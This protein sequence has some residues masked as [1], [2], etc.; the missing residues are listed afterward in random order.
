MPSNPGERGAEPQPGTDDSAPGDGPELE[1]VLDRYLAERA[2]GEEPDQQRYLREHPA[3]AEALRGVFRTLDFVE[4]TSRSLHASKLGCG[5]RV[6]E[7]RIVREVGRGGM[8][9]VYEAVQVPLHRRVALKVLPPGASLSESA[10]ERFAREAATAGRLHHTNI[11]PVYAVGQQDELLYYA[12]QFIDGRSLAE[13]LTGW[14]RAD[15]RP[16]LDHHRRVAGWGRQVAE[17]IDY[18]HSQGAIHRDIK[19]ANLLLDERDDVWITDFGLAREDARATITISGDVIG[20]ARYM[21]PE[22]AKGGREQLDGRTDVYSLGATLYE[23]LA[24]TPAIDDESREAV[25]N[26]LATA[27]A[28]PLR[29]IDRS[30][31]RDLETIVAKCMARDAGRRYQRASELADDLRRFLAGDPIRA[32]RTPL[33]VKTARFAG[34]HRTPVLSS[35]IVLAVLVAMVLLG[36]QFR[37]QQGRDRLDAAYTA[38][39]FEHDSSRAQALLDE[40]ERLGVRSTELHLYRGLIPLLSAQP[41][42]AIAPLRAAIEQQPDNVEANLAMAYALCNTGDESGSQ[43]YDAAVGDE[44]INTPLGW[45]L[46]GYTLVITE[47]SD[48]IGAYNRALAVQPDFTPAIEARAQARGQRLL[49]EGD[50][51]QLT[52]MLDDFDAWVRFWPGSARS[53]AARA[54]GKTQAAAFAATQP[55]LAGQAA[56]WLA[57]AEADYDRA[58]ELTTGS[59]AGVLVRRGSHRRYLGD[60]A[61]SADDFGRA[62][63]EDTEAAGETHPGYVHH[64]VLALH[65]LGETDRA[66]AAVE[67]ACE[68]L[69][70]FAPLA[71][72][73]AM[74]LAELGRLHEARRACR[75]TL[76]RQSGSKTGTLLA[77][78]VMELLGE[79]RAAIG[80]V[81]ALPDEDTPDPLLEWF[82][83]ELDSRA[84]LASAGG[85]PGRRCQYALAIAMRELGQ[86]RR[87]AGVAAL[88]ECLATGVIPYA[89]FRFAQVL[90]ARAAADPDWPAWAA[91]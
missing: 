31:P 64:L 78:S 81:A 32:R 71:L 50:R 24:L 27:E 69:P 91:E 90:R 55:D 13:H 30:I 41:Q 36:L 63:A 65:A 28:R 7:F 19:P 73:R 72:Q 53:Y 67:P 70:S 21:S 5:Q 56:A 16:G 80:S 54:S 14:R 23:L 58:L 1:Q 29:Q 46:R 89:H 48:P 42:R 68:A 66:L 47:R 18:A 49:I 10:S 57:Q 79:T 6:G 17:A 88:D 22:Q 43:R 35:A 37:L 9:V 59:P 3:L 83:G 34:R 33:I 45:L 4:A 76:A 8:G 87:D 85:H 86:G 82:A 39:L 51:S 44:D 25:L 20:T 60:Y 11:V 62:I 84:L 61:G 52:P 12:M 40:A 75:E 2:A 74:L 77:A 26:R 38:L 15:G